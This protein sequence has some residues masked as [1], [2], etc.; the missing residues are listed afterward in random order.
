MQGNQVIK[1]FSFFFYCWLL[2]FVFVF[3]FS[4]SSK[5]IDMKWPHCIHIRCIAQPKSCES[6][7]RVCANVHISFVIACVFESRQ[8]FSLVW[9]RHRH[10]LLV[11]WPSYDSFYQ[12][13]DGNIL[14]SIYVPMDVDTTRHEHIFINISNKIPIF[15]SEKCRQPARFTAMQRRNGARA[16]SHNT[17]SNA[18][19]STNGCMDLAYSHNNNFQLCDSLNS[20]SWF[21]SSGS[22]S[23][24]NCTP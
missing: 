24:S 13:R 20:C 7:A 2:L 12:L 6:I 22:S 4:I 19:L 10:I 14:I 15:A 5:R 16:D 11:S 23:S 1:M 9:H 17:A 3:N 21:N 8:Q 18:T